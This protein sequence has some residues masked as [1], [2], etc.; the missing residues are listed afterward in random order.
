[1]TSKDTKDK[2]HWKMEIKKTEEEMITDPLQG[3]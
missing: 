2:N 1:M 3:C